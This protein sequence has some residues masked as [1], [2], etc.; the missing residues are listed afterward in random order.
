MPLPF[1][2][3]PLALVHPRPI[4]SPF[5]LMPLPT[6][7]TLTLGHVLTYLDPHRRRDAP[8]PHFASFSLSP[9]RLDGGNARHLL[10]HH[11]S[12]VSAL[13]LRPPKPS[14]LSHSGSGAQGID[15]HDRLNY[16]H[17]YR[18]RSR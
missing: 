14:G 3:S 1:G 9:P 18:I 6:L 10:P 12:R 7:L 13:L 15:T 4:L 5:S 8:S 11:Q 2:F 17:R 16:H